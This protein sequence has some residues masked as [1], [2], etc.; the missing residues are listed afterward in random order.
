VKLSIEKVVVGG[1]G[2]ARIPAEVER[3]GGMRAFV[4]FTLP[5]E[6]VEAAIREKHRGYCTAEVQTI[7]R[8]SQ[9]RVEPPCPWFGTCGGCQ[10]QHSIYDNQVDIKREM[11]VETLQRSGIRELPEI[12]TQASK[13][14]GYRNRVR[15]HVHS[16]HP[17]VLGYRRARSHSTTDIDHCPIA[18][19]L[20]QRL[21]GV[22]HMHGQQQAIPVGLQEIELFSNQNQ[23]AVL[24]TCWVRENGKFE[25]EV[26]LDFLAT[27][28]KEVPQLT[29]ASI[30]PEESPQSNVAR[31]LLQ[32]GQTALRYSAGGRDYTVSQGSFFQINM[33][34]LDTFMTAVT[35]GESGSVAWD[36]FAGVGL[37]SLLLSDKFTRVVAVESNPSACKDFRANLRDKDAPL[38]RSTVLDFLKRAAAVREA[39]P[40]L[41]LLDPPRT[42]LGVECCGLLTRI[43]PRRIV[44]VSCDPATLGRDLAVLIQSGYH[45]QRLQLVDM[46]PQTHHL[47][48]IATLHR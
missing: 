23:S 3:L 29:G 33:T 18:A 42:G 28:N 16:R 35:G 48:T 41:V 26:W 10:L 22:L 6:F 20:L 19:S 2:L 31:P 25:P 47:E 40:D 38:V 1:Q 4:P 36:L 39:A 17:F 44:Y 8:A 21:I 14:F 43:G 45:L 15:L 34:L 46:F 32:W 7:E 12:T 5:G 37:F 9:F 11:L 13:P 27:L 30:F 24:A